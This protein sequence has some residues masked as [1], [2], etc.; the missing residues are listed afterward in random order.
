MLVGASGSGKSSF[1]ARHF[2]RYEAVSS[3]VC[4]G[5][6]SDD[7]NDQ[8][9]TAAAFALV[10]HIAGV[11][12]DAGLL[13]V[14]DATSVQSAAR[15]QLVRVARSHDVLPVAIVLDVE[16]AVCAARNAARPDRDFGAHV[17]A[18]QVSQLKRSL[19]GLKREGFRTV[20]VLRG[21]AQVEA[22]SI[23]RT[24]LRTDRTDLT[25]P[26]DVIGDVHG[27]RAEL[28][29]LMEALGYALVRDGD[30]PPSTR[31]RRPGAARCSSATSSTAA[32]TAPGCCA[33]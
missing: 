30:G 8:S 28:E 2:G 20:H 11:R 21:A 33:W 1:A 14:V 26:F 9:A 19:K 22:A 5:V 16:E 17:V 13:T 6:V 4:R 10:E 24:P 3:D 31:C 25:G 29:E 23:V 12:L 27:C 7:E 32:P 18:R 15:A